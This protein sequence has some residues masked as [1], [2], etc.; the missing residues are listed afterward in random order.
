MNSMCWRSI[1]GRPSFYGS[2][3]SDN[4]IRI[5]DT[6]TGEELARFEAPSAAT[7]LEVSPDG[8]RLIAGG[9]VGSVTIWD[10]RHI[11]TPGPDL[12]KIV[13]SRLNLVQDGV[14]LELDSQV[15][16]PRF[17]WISDEIP[18]PDGWWEIR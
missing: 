12:A 7:I 15:W 18:M 8:Y 14:S 16:A 17:K 2:R 5:W 4:T 11:R 13:L 6:G 10:L 9:L 3:G 1:R